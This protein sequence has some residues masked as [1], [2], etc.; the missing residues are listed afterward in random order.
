[1]F[2]L[3]PITSE[4]INC[5]M[6]TIS[7]AVNDPDA[8]ALQESAEF[9]DDAFGV[10]A[11]DL[12]GTGQDNGAVIFLEGDRQGVRVT[13]TTGKIGEGDI[14]LVTARCQYL[15]ATKD[16][17]I[18]DFSADKVGEPFSPFAQILASIL[19]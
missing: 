6:L 10:A 9:A 8:V 11:H 15:L 3:N 2:Q 13:H 7:I 1:M 14:G 4:G 12:P 18:D 17:G 16:R 19:D 5:P